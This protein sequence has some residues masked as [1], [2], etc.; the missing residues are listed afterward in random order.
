MRPKGRGPLPLTL[1]PGLGAVG[2]SILSVA[3]TESRQRSMFTLNFT[4]KHSFRVEGEAQ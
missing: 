1:P 3:Y 2:V 4:A